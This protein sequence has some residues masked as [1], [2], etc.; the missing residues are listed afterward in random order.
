[1]P[2]NK[3]SPRRKGAEEHRYHGGLM[4][5]NSDRKDSPSQSNLKAGRK[6]G[7][8]GEK[9]PAS[10]DSEDTI[11]NFQPTEW[12]PQDSAYGAAC[13]LCGCLS[14]RTRKLI[15]FSMIAGMFIGFVY[16]LVT[17][18]INLT[19]SKSTKTLDGRNATASDQYVSG[20][21]ALDDDLYAA[22]NNNDDGDDDAAAVDNDDTV[23][24]ND[25]NNGYRRLRLR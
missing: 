1:M 17:T 6:F 16:L 9:I 20:Q 13:P 11:S 7:F 12:T 22:Y 25:D 3:S 21:I 18:S 10:Q 5:A 2:W 14:K 15:E 8:L 24:Y 4:K 23:Y 19:N